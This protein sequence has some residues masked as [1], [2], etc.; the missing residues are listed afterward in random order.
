MRFSRLLALAALLVLPA[1]VV[2][3]DAPELGRIDVNV[4]DQ[5]GTPLNGVTVQVRSSGGNILEE[6]ATGSVG[7]PGY[8]LVLRAA[9]EYRVQVVAPTGYSV[10]ASQQNPVPVTLR[11]DQTVTVNFTLAAN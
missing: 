6:G 4:R 2:S 9:G 5:A 1:C 3:P 8:Y 10:P 7:T 11:T